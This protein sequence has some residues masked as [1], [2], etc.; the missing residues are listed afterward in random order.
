MLEALKNHG[1]HI[2]KD[3]YSDNTSVVSIPMHVEGDTA[4][5]KTM[6]EQLQLAALAQK[7]WADNSVSVTISFDRSAVTKEEI[8]HSILDGYLSLKGKE[9]AN[10]ALQIHTAPLSY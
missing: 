10:L 1:Y 6:W 5:G 3:T 4:K 7:Y 2:E 9:R 8:A